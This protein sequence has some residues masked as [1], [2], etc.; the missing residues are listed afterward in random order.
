VNIFVLGRGNVGG[1]LARGW[2]RAGHTVTVVGRE[3]GDA[4]DA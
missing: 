1:G 2:E 4:T 3:G